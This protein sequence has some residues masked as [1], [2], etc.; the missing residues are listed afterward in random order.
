MRERLGIHNMR[1]PRRPSRE[2]TSSLHLGVGMSMSF[3]ILFL[4]GWML[5]SPL[6]LAVSNN[7]LKLTL[8]VTLNLVILNFKFLTIAW[9][10]HT[11]S[12]EG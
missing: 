7:P 4:S 6:G 8:G 11:N 12:K 2:R 1:V 5:T 9:V 3:S 10:F